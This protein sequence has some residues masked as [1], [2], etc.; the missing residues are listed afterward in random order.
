MNS[1]AWPSARETCWS[2]NASCPRKRQCRSQIQKEAADRLVSPPGGKDYG[3]LT[4]ACARWGQGRITLKVPPGAFVPPPKVDSA[5]IRIRLY[6]EPPVSVVSEEML[7]RT[8]RGAFAQR[9]KTLANSL[10]TEFSALGR[11]GIAAA[12]TAAGLEPSVRGERLGLAD[13]ARL[14]DALGAALTK[15]C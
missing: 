4:V 5:V 10:G 8:I 15:D 13:F 7:F 11:E 12:I 9:R 6:R 3:P 2:G 1:G 14:S